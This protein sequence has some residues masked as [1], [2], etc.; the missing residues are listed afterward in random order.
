MQLKYSGLPSPK[1]VRI[2]KSKDKT[3]LIRFFNCE[4]IVHQEFIPPD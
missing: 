3:L 2:S 4:G 1:K